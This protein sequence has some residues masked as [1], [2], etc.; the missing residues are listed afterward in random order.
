[1]TRHLFRV[2][3]LAGLLAA[4]AASA[5]PAEPFSAGARELLSR[6]R[7]EEW[8]VTVTRE[9]ARVSGD[10]PLAARAYDLVLSAVDPAELPEDV[11][12]AARDLHQAARAA[13]AAWRRGVPTAALRTELRAAWM[14]R[15]RSA[16]GFALHLERRGEQSVE[17]FAAGTRRAWDPESQG[18]EGSGDDPA[19][20]G[21]GPR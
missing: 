13:D 5:L 14:L 18:R 8:A 16:A 15:S 4:G 7:G 19:G 11:L 10:S 3:A 20:A 17:E 9:I 2:S 1:M 21:G 12:E 6:L